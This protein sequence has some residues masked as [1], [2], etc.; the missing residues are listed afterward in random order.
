MDIHAPPRPHFIDHD[1][2]RI[3]IRHRV[4][5]PARATLMCLPGYGSD[6]Q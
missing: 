1:G 2:D 5:A 3:A 4:A 6:R